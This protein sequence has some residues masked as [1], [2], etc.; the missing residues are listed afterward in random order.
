MDEEIVQKF[1]ERK[2]LHAAYYEDPEDLS[3]PI[4]E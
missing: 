3:V 1:D 4:K 2:V